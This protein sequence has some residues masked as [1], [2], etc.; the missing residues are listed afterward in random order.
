[1][2]YSLYNLTVESKVRLDHFGLELSKETIVNNPV[3]LFFIKEE[4]TKFIDYIDHQTHYDDNY[5]Y[6]YFKEIALY[7]VHNGER[8]V[9]K[10]FNDIDNDLIH[11]LLNYPFAI[12]FKQR[13]K[14]II[15]AASVLFNEKVFCFCGQT[16]SGKSSIASHL[17][18]NGGKLIS[19]DTCV[20]DYF[21][22]ELYILPSYNFLKI[23]D[24]VNMH[25]E[26]A[27]SKPIK[28]KKKSF[29]RNGYVLD[30]KMFYTKP[31]KVDCFIYLNW[32]DESASF[33]KLNLKDSLGMLLSNEFISFNKNGAA[34]DF[35][36]ALELANTSNHFNY[37]RKKELQSLNDFI[38][39]ALNIQ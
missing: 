37:A 31:I 11:T 30:S 32:T 7:E 18:K 35:K 15:H 14:Y 22:D 4:D 33:E 27:F 2:Y 5:S 8:I 28:F 19:E 9:I 38:Q 20:F 21:N 17:I 16:Q 1:M 39:I 13:N 26:F 10:Y 6:Y 29:K 36:L 12:L 24:E 3:K 34:L 23:S 25:H